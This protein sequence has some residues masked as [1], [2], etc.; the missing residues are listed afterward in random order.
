MTVRQPFRQ[1]TTRAKLTFAIEHSAPHL[2]PLIEAVRDH[3]IGMLF[4]PQGTEAFRIPSDPKRP[5]VVIIGDDF[6]SA[7]GPTGFHMPSIRRAIRACHAFAVISSEPQP[8]VYAEVAVTAAIAR[9][10]VMLIE[11]RPEQEIPWLSLVQKLAPG[12]FIWLA[13]VQGGRA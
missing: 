9:C 12:R 4:A 11:T 3:S 1:A 5:A 7:M 6:D 2:R 13:T 8:A 10:N